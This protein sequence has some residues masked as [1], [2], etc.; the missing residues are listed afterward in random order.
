MRVKNNIDL[1][2][3]LVR[4]RTSE[5]L[6]ILV[7]DKR[8]ICYR[9]TWSFDGLPS[10]EVLPAAYLINQSYLRVTHLMSLGVYYYNKEMLNGL[11]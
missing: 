10:I 9:R 5:E 3:T 1:D 7:K 2:S 6:L 11:Q 4:I 8:S